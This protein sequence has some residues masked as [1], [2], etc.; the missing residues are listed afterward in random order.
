MPEKED[1][2]LHR[3]CVLNGEIMTWMNRIRNANIELRPTWISPFMPAWMEYSVRTGKVRAT[4]ELLGA[5]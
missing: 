1:L 4:R 5:D 2:G 3:A